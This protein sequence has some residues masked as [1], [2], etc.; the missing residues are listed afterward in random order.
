MPITA[1]LDFATLGDARQIGLVL[2]VSDC[3]W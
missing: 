3:P 1:L 2:F